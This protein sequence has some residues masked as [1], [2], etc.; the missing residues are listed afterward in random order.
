[1]TD[2]LITRKNVIFDATVLTAVMNCP[3][4][5]D[6]RFNH[7]LVSISG[8]GNSLE[9][10]SIVHKFLEMFY[11]A[12]INGLKRDEAFA[13]GYAAAQLYI[14]GCRH[15]TGFTPSHHDNDNSETH[16]CD[17]RCII[18][19]V[20]GH[21]PNEYPGTQVPAET[22]A[23]KAYIIGWRWV[24]QTI[25]EYNKFW[26]NDSWVPLEVEVV[27]SKVLYE[28]EEIRVMWKSKL[29]WVVDTD[30][31]IVAVDHKSMKQNRSATKLNNQFIGQ[32]LIMGTRTMF[33]NKVGFQ[34]TLP[35]E[36]RFVRE[37]KSYDAD[38]LLEWQS[39]TLPFYA[40]MLLAYTE[41]GY[42][43][44]NFT[45]CQSKFG[46][47]Q[48]LEGCESNRDMREQ[49]LKDNFVVGPDWDPSNE[50]IIDVE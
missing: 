22:P 14:A 13:I 4:F 27:K 32:N 19:P 15:C 12:R 35:P 37:G 23:D 33:L 46:D 2:I 25:E 16:V 36:K 17:D 47:C 30:K 45:N 41:M 31:G 18:K 40:K 42:F 3:R 44:P 26:I 50:S 43:P 10:G 38:T 29:D 5:A 28:D 11:K 7:N 39:Q 6:L 9:C 8:K 21:P 20:C 1:M 34:K 48:F 24:L 49:W